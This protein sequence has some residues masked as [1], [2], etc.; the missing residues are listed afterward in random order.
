MFMW[1]QPITNQGVSMKNIIET[2][3]IVVMFAVILYL[4]M[5]A[6]GGI[7]SNTNIMSNDYRRA[8][9]VLPEWLI[10]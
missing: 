7:E 9:S 5:T 3:T 8:L 1:E 2:T 4:L 10:K 6:L